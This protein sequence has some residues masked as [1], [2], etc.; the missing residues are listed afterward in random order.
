MCDTD[1]SLRITRLAVSCA[2]AGLLAACGSSEPTEPVDAPDVLEF[3]IK[4]IGSLD[5]TGQVIIEANPGNGTLKSLVDSTLLVLTAGVEAK[6]LDVTTNLTTKPLYFVGVHRV[7]NQ[8]AS[9]FS[10]WTLVG[11]DDPA[12]LTSLV[13]VSGFAQAA[14]GAAPT[15][16]SGTIG[17]G[18]GVVN[19]LLLAVGNGGL[20]T[21][22]RPTSGT[23]S[24]ASIASG[25]TACPNFQSN[26]NLT[27]TLE[28]MRVRFTINAPGGTGGASAR[29]AAVSMDVD[30]P[31]MRLTYTF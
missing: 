28:T 1:S 23:V 12:K 25:G 2:V 5:S 8:G 27:C 14:N 18:T 26:G 24:F 7:V 16:V 15:T 3:T 30:V 31:T 6:R 22:W 4:Q 13:E 17:D 10:T 11:M 9:A 21:E 19:G 20:V 29:S